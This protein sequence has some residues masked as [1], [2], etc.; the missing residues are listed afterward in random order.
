[1][2]P[3]VWYPGGARGPR[4]YAANHMLLDLSPYVKSS[5]L[6]MADFFKPLVDFATIDNKLVAM[7]LGVTLSV[8]IYN[9]V[10]FEEAGLEAPPSDWADNSWTWDRFLDS[11]KRLTVDVNGDGLPDRFGHDYWNPGEQGTPMLFGGDWFDDAGYATGYPKRSRAADQETVR[12][13]R[14]LADA[15]HVWRVMPTS[16]DVAR[17]G[18]GRVSHITPSVQKIM[19]GT[20]APDVELQDLQRRLDNLIA[21]GDRGI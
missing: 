6:N 14:F 12:A 10:L 1:M 17:L 4:F 13:L 3:N 11:A 21:R 16:A 20:V 8:L 5:R 19:A 2:V 15:T 9:P 7:P 18:G